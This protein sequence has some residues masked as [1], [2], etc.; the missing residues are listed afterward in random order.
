[1]SCKTIV[2]M[3]GGE[4][5]SRAA[6]GSH[7]VAGLG[8]GEGQSGVVV[9]CEKGAAKMEGNELPLAARKGQKLG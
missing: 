1:M 5:L 7:R 3:W 4:G 6:R 9:G 8:E 2:G